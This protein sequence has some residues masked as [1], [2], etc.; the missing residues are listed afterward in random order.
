MNDTHLHILA[1]ADGGPETLVLFLTLTQ[2]LIGGARIAAVPLDH[3]VVGL[4]T[5]GIGKHSRGRVS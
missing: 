2:V 3:E 1:G 5:P 4:A